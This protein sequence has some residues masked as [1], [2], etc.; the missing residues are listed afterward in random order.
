MD[1]HPK[2]GW[3]RV[4]QSPHHNP[5]H[6]CHSK[7]EMLSP[8]CSLIVLFYHI[9]SVPYPQHFETMLCCS[10]VTRWQCLPMPRPPRATRGCQGTCKATGLTVLLRSLWNFVDQ[11][12]WRVGAGGPNRRMS[13]TCQEVQGQP[14]SATTGDRQSD[15]EHCLALKAPRNEVGIAHDCTG[16]TGERLFCSTFSWDI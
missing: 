1:L 5:V 15:I 2:Q 16:R 12:C 11:H 14:M 6:Q 8:D 3:L 7:T 10:A 9:L 4:S 13:M